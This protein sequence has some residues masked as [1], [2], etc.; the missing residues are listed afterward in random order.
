MGLEQKTLPQSAY[1]ELLGLLQTLCQSKQLHL[2]LATTRSLDY[3]KFQHLESGK[4]EI[5][6]LAA[7]R[8]A[9]ILGL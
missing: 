9:G 3:T 2:F 7:P 1:L 4:M 8:D 5:S 6:S